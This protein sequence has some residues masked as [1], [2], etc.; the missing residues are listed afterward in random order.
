MSDSKY[1]RIFTEAEVENLVH[2]AGVTGRDYASLVQSAVGKDGNFDSAY[3]FPEDEPLFIL[4]A[5]DRRALAAIRE[6]YAQC[7]N[8]CDQN[9]LDAI[10]K[11]MSDFDKFR[12]TYPDRM[13]IPD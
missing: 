8:V 1:G 6:Y 12:Q 13:K 4:R 9:H 10:E 2:V 5:Q 7:M 11:A 3:V